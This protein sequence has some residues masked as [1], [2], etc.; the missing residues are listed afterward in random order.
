MFSK[1]FGYALRAA[2]YVALHGTGSKKVS[3]LE[4]SKE[5]G[6]PHYFLAKIMQDLVRHGVVDS[7]K[8]PNGGFFVNARTAKTP[9]IAVL[10]I[11]DGSLIFSQ[12]A[13]GIKHCSSEHPCPLHADFAACRDGML[14]T[15]AD[16]T[17]GTLTASVEAGKSYLGKNAPY[18]VE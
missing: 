8:G 18:I 6:I 10:H 1:T 17:I 11:T 9:L 2:T 16:K 13:L 12:C 7:V 3:L 5:L 14:Q 4:M 15:L